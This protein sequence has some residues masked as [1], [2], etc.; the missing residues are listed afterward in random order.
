MGIGLFHHRVHHRESHET[1][2]R[3]CNGCKIGSGVGGAKEDNTTDRAQDI[4]VAFFCSVVAVEDCILTYE[5]AQAM[6]DKNYWTSICLMI[7][8]SQVAE[9]ENEIGSMI[10]DGIEA[11]FSSKMH[12]ISVIPICD[13]SS[14]RQVFG[15]QEFGPWLG[16]L[17]RSPCAITTTGQAVK[18]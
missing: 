8:A 5:T 18:K 16:A 10:T 11:S 13:D 2:G 9:V 17:R 7:P 15:Q 12:Y 1:C 14:L 3:I 4:L 6:N